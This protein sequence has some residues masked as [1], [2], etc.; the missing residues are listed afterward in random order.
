MTWEE[1]LDEFRALGGIAENARLDV[2]PLGRGIFPID[3]SKPVVLHCP[4]ALQVRLM[5]LE[6]RDGKMQAKPEFYGA[7]ERAFFEAYEEQFGWSAGGSEESW[8]QQLAW[9][10]LPAEIVNAMQTMGMLD[11]IEQRFAPPNVESCKLDYL[12]AR[13]FQRDGGNY[14][15]PIID[16]VNHSSYVPTYVYENGI[17]VAGTFS[18]EVLVR[19]NAADAWTLAQRYG[20]TTMSPIAYSIGI[21]VAIAGG[22]RLTVARNI[23]ELV[24]ENGVQY[25]KITVDADGVTLAHLAL[26]FSMAKDLPRAIFRKIMAPRLNAPQADHIFDGIQEFN[27]NEFITLLRKLRKYD[28]PLVHTLEEAVINQLETLNACV[29]A[30]NL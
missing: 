6:M 3:P 2:G 13:L 25:P 23:N 18:D 24:V 27:R 14:V 1:L 11:G 20:F 30:R 12:H 10:E 19:Y 26:G 8:Q 15:V 17:G 5:H 22:K 9:S 4:Y 16:L 7:R 21:N 29:G 28:G